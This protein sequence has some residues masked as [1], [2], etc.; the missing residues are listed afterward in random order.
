MGRSTKP[1]LTFDSEELVSYDGDEIARIH[2]AYRLR[3]FAE[4][5]PDV[6]VP[7]A[8]TLVAHLQSS[9]SLLRH[10]VAH[11][12]I[13][14]FVHSEDPGP[15]SDHVSE[16]LPSLTDEIRC[17][18]RATASSIIMSAIR[19]PDEV[20][21]IVSTFIPALT[22]A[23]SIVQ[24]YIA[25]TLT[26]IAEEDPKAVAPAAESLIVCLDT[27]EKLVQSHTASALGLLASDPMWCLHR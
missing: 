14:A 5:W 27:D 23:D 8:A 26:A 25:G 16:L 7:H 18:R 17:V 20:P 9:N 1:Y 2:A 3:L 15:I 24:G 13:P 19:A 6:V 21:P 11:I 12:I 22:D 10:Y 4:S